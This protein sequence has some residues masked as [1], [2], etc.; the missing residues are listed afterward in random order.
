MLFESDK[1][2]LKKPQ[3]GL[4]TNCGEAGI[5]TPD[6]DLNPYNRLATCRFQPLSHLS[7]LN[8]VKSKKHAIII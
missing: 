6:R 2:I 3:L 5:R 4:F 7:F 8:L 1:L